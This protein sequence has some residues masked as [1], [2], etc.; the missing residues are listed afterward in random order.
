MR[1]G[2]LGRQVKVLILSPLFSADS[3]SCAA[4]IDDLRKDQEWTVFVRMVRSAI[5]GQA[6][7]ALAQHITTSNQPQKKEGVSI[8]LN[9]CGADQPHEANGWHECHIALRNLL[10]TG[11]GI[12]LNYK[13]PPMKSMK[14]AL[15]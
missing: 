11:D 5:K 7:H 1:A 3:D 9:A 8:S 10:D 14:Q 15:W 6:R 2:E 13:S 12:A 4:E